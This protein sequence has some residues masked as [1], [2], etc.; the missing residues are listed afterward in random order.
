MSLTLENNLINLG[1]AMQ[2]EEASPKVKEKSGQR[3]QRYAKGLLPK[4]ENKLKG[5][6]K[7]SKRSRA[8]QSQVG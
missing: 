8:A 6:G 2:L 5:L 1:L 7:R 4:Q 3:G